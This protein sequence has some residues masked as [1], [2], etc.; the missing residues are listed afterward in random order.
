MA[1]MSIDHAILILEDTVMILAGNISDF[2]LDQIRE[3]VDV[4]IDALPEDVTN[5]L[6]RE[7]LYL[8]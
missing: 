1:K 8:Q 5:K 4:L 6:N 3:A 2:Y 7:G